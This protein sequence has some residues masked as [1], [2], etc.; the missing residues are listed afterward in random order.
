MSLSFLPDDI[1]SALS[2]LNYNFLTEI[3]LRRG[4]PVIIE[5]Q[6]AYRYLGRYGVSANDADRL[7][8]LDISSV[9]NAATG[10]CIYGYTEQIKSGFITVE[11]G[12]RIGIAGEYVTENGKV[13]TIKNITSLNIRIPHDVVGCSGSIVNS[14][15]R[16]GPVSTLIFSKP[17]LGKT[18]MLR[19]IARSIIKLQICN[20]LI[21][22]E[23]GEIAAIDAYGDGFDLGA[24]DVVRCYNKKGAIASAVRAMKPQ[25]IITDELYGSDDI[26]AVKYI[27][28]CGITVIASSHVCDKN[29]LKEMP[30]EYFV[31]LKSIN[32]QPIIYDKNF[33][34]YCDSSADD[35]ARRFSVRG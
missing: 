6:G 7:Y 1:K 34:S 24:V 29:I 19:D 30:F 17:G 5:Y 4:Q 28:D 12:V 16:C 21:F 20:V 10:G 8:I 32:G 27:T 25:I 26:A 23:R 2:H 31:E 18:T 35:C 15:F 13:N 9:L 33:N 11:H 14:L 3:R 22:D